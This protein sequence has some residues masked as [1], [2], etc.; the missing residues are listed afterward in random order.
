MCMGGGGGGP[1]PAPVPAALPPPP[2]QIDPSV[3]AARQNARDRAAQANG[4]ASTIAGSSV[5]TDLTDT[6]SQK[7]AL[8][9]Q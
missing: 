1:A 3:L 9:G 7:K 8:L 5:S 4:R 2:T 6:S